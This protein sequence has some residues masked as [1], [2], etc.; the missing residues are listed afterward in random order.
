MKPKLEDKRSFHIDK[1]KNATGRYNKY[2]QYTL[3]VRAPNFIKLM[4]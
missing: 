2:K 1:G 4:K 3:N